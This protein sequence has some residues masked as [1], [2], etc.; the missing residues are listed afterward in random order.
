LTRPAVESQP[1]P[2]AQSSGRRLPT[3]LLLGKH[4]LA[5]IVATAVDYSMMIIMV[6]VVG[7]T[8]VEGTVIGA[9]TGASVNFTMGRYFTFRA[10]HGRAEGQAFRYVLVSAASLG[11][12]AL[13]EHL[14]AVVLGLHYVIARLI[15]GTLVSFLWNYPLQRYFVFK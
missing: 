14:L 1:P 10:S 8:A 7:L 4:Q 2:P 13:G 15:T 6:S 3:I 12:N 11:W 5:S 9:A